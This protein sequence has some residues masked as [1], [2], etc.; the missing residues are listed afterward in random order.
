[1]DGS[2]KEAKSN[3]ERHDEKISQTLEN[4]SKNSDV[5][6][7]DFQTFGTLVPTISNFW[8]ECVPIISNI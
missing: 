1:M 7:K 3:L 6:P 4:I 5:C 8:D 2:V